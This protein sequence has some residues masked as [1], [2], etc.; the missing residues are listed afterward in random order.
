MLSAR[1]S[2]H[3]TAK[4]GSRES[5]TVSG[6]PQ[7]ASVG[8]AADGFRTSVD[9]TDADHCISPSAAGCAPD[10][11][12]RS[13]HTG[14]RSPLSRGRSPSPS[15]SHSRPIFM[16]S[17]DF[18]YETA[19]WGSPAC[20]YGSKRLG[21]VLHR[22]WNVLRDA[23]RR[24]PYLDVNPPERFLLASSLPDP[25]VNEVSVRYVSGSMSE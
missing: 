25:L 16:S 20:G 24:S 7:P 18:D 5:G 21:E 10:A 19:N 3:L 11:R 1:P 12:K 14:C 13:P 15:V 17:R 6:R 4:R 22:Q 2:A 8:G 23:G 9:F